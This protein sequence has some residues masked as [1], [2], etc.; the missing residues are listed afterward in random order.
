MLS[1]Y[2]KLLNGVHCQNAA[3][4]NSKKNSKKMKISK[5]AGA[6]RFWAK[7]TSACDL[8]A[9][10]IEVCECACVRPKNPSQLT[11]CGFSIIMIL[12]FSQE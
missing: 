5:R 2:Q 8:R 9:A 1:Y 4:K 6:L 3:S 7:R 10:E 12:N 11:L